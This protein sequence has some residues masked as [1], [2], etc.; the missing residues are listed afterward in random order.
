MTCFSPQ[1]RV[2]LS[3]PES[4]KLVVGETCSLSL[5]LPKPLETRIEMQVPGN[6]KSVFA[7]PQDCP[8]SVTRNNSGY[9]IAALRPGKVE[10]QLKLLGYIPIRSISVESVATKRVVPG[11]HSIGVLLQSNGIMVVGFAPVTTED[12]TKVYPARANG[13]QIGDLIMKVNGKRVRSETELAGIID[14]S[15]RP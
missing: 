5:Q 6:S 12:G 10:L 11:G 4:Q 13:V 14:E 7:S 3:M 9:E 1:G 2:L 15:K 8:V